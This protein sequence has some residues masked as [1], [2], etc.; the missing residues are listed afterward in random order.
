MFTNSKYPSGAY[1][2][3][4]DDLGRIV[5]P[6]E[7][8]RQLKVRDGNP[9]VIQ[10][11][12]GKIY[13]EPYSEIGDISWL[14]DDY[15]AALTESTHCVCL[16]TDREF[17]IACGHTETKKDFIN[18]SLGS[19]IR[20]VME[21][22]DSYHFNADNDGDYA[23]EFSHGSTTKIK[24]CTIE[25]IFHHRDVVGAIVLYSTTKPLLAI[26]NAIIKTAALFIKKTI[27]KD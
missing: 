19:A 3:R 11:I 5:I 14:A 1:V 13:M 10:V 15:A 9:M 12:E 25:P 17:I 6:K 7:L 24:G 16:I 21:E 18:S 23:L 4:I 8:R 22:E 2:R 20:G 27:E 26:H